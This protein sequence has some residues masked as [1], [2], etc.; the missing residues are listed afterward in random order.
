MKVK[1]IVD[2][3]GT[4]NGQAWPPRGTPIELPDDEALGYIH[5]G[6]A[7]PVVDD[8]TETAIADTADVE[9]RALTTETGPVKRGPGRP[10]KATSMPED[11]P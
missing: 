4:R 3:S 10:R 6:M 7:V 8:G 5:G 2:Q 11:K 9:T 1:M